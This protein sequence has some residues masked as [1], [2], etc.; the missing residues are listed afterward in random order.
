MAIWPFTPSRAKK[1]ADR[2][3]IAVTEASRRPALFGPGRIPDTMEGRF[4]AMVLN[5]ALALIRLRTEPGAEPLAQSFTDKLFLLFDAGLREAGVG[6]LTVPKRM[7]ALAGSFYGR[8][9]AY[10][11]PIAASD[12]A[13]LA[14]ALSRNV[15]GDSP[16]AAGLA[17]HVLASA[18]AQSQTPLEALFEP[19]GWPAPPA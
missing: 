3:L 1:D 15:V 14:A 13:A 19:A 11:A 5:G 16:F 17:G 12:A 8:L 10:A 7:R 9:D 4:E 18:Q 2:L 6:D